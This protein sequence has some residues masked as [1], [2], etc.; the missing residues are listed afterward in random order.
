MKKTLFAASLGAL[1]VTTAFSAQADERWPRWYLGLT[2]DYTIMGNED[3]SGSRASSLQL[4]D[5]YGFGGAI[6]YL[7]SSSIPLINALRFE[8]E[9]S[10][11]SNGVSRVNFNGG[12]QVNGNGSYSSTAY[13]VNTYYDY[14]MNSPWSP[15]IGFGLGFAT[16]HLPTSSGAG[17]SDESDNE[18][19]YQGMLG[20]G[21]TPD[22]IPN[23]QWTLG[24]RYLATSDPSFNNV[25]SKYSTNNIEVG[26][27]FRF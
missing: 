6:G 9:V 10:Y 26:G 15:Y 24:Y 11:H 14:P 18:F 22:S 3:V 13:M 23:T 5:G 12:G 8:A 17:N 20:I 2:G 21:Y 27:K 4:N 16:V 25:S 7:P 1:L 19:A